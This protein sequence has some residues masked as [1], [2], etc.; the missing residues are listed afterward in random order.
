MHQEAMDG[1]LRRADQQLDSVR[2]KELSFYVTGPRTIGR[3]RKAKRGTINAARPTYEEALLKA[4][5]SL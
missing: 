4:M 3:Y 1:I 5:L 2:R